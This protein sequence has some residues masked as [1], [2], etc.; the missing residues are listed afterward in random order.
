MDNL[1]VKIYEPDDYDKVMK[2][3]QG[4]NALQEIEEELFANAV[5]IVADETIYGMITYELF[6][7]KALIRYFIFDKDVEEK[8]LIEMYEKFFSNLKANKI[9]RVFVIINSEEIKKMFINLGFK[10]FPKESFFLT[11]ESILQTKY[12]NAHVLYYEIDD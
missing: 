2:F 3:L 5:L 9:N 10:E 12:K 1:Y 6:R 11:E 7:Q 4:V 8:Y